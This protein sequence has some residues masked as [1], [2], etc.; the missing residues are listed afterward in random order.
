MIS[1]EPPCVDSLVSPPPETLFLF[2]RVI[3]SYEYSEPMQFRFA[4]DS[5][6]KVASYLKMMQM[7]PA[8]L[9]EKAPASLAAYLGQSDEEQEEEEERGAVSV[10]GGEDHLAL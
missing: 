8:V 9:L 4:I 2:G 1:L 5:Q 6:L 7:V 10:E 3:T